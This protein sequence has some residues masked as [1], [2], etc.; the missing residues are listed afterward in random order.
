M[1]HD[2]PAD[3]LQ[4]T[5]DALF[6]VNHSLSLIID[7]IR[8]ALKGDTCRTK[9]PRQQ[10]TEYQKLLWKFYG[11]LANR[12][13]KGQSENN[14]EA[15]TAKGSSFAGWMKITNVRNDLLRSKR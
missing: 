13:L 14:D 11:F 10:T 9:F 3:R 15:A 5:V 6:R 2:L 4:P 7:E 8:S 12:H 1:F